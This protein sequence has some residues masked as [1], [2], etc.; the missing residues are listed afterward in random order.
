M[1]TKTCKI[2]FLLF[3]ALV[4]IK[5]NAITTDHILVIKSQRIMFLMNGNEINYSIPISLGKKPI[6]TKIYQGDKRTP[7]GIY[8]I[9]HKNPQSKFFLSLGIDYPRK[10]DRIAA[11]KAGKKPGGDIMIHGLPNK[12]PKEI[13]SGF[14]GKDWTDGCIAVNNNNLMKFLYEHINVGTKIEIIP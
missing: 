2:L 9:S 10:K 13:H 7:E 5:A 8:R 1:F 6:G 14:K 3:S 4:C 11:K 12:A